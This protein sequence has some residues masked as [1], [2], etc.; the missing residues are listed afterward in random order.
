M[1]VVFMSNE[2][3]KLFKTINDFDLLRRNER[4]TVKM[5]VGISPCCGGKEN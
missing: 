2:F 1:H 3:L 4:S 5:T